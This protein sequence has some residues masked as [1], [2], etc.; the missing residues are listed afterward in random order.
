[1][2]AAQISLEGVDV[3]IKGTNITVQAGGPCSVQG[4]PIQLN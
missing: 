4:L 1:M 3:E 2:K